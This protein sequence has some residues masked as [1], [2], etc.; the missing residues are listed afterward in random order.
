MSNK[1]MSTKKKGDLLENVVEQLCSGIKGIKV[2]RNAKVLGEQSKVNRDVDVLIEGQVGAFEVKI[3]IEAKNYSSPVGV[4]KVESLITKLKDIGS[5]LGVMVCPL[6]FYESAKNL[7]FANGIKLFEVYDPTLGNSKLFI[8]LR[9][10]EPVI[11]SFG[12]GIRHR[13]QGPFEITQ[14]VTRW[15]FHIGNKLL[16]AKQ[17]VL[18]AWNNNM[19]PHQAGQHTADFNAVTIS[20]VNDP[21]RLQYCEAYI[22]IDVIEKYFLK[23][24]PASFLK[25]IENQKEQFNLGIDIYS[26]DEDMLQHGWKQF[27]N[28]DEM[29]KAAEIDNQPVGVRELLVRPD[30]SLDIDLADVED[31]K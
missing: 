7:A 30:Y 11:R 31:L 12:F 18:F 1:H 20:D 14:D 2:T 10:V 8:P 4:E 19:I 23:L 16:N 26:R 25:N 9:Y 22:K 3:A 24:F 6:G 21:S 13:T 5:N 15:R 29:N 28:L 17:M 27:E